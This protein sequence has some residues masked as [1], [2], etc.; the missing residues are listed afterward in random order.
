MRGLSGKYGSK[1]VN[2][3]IWEE[4]SATT[5]Q[6]LAEFEHLHLVDFDFEGCAKPCR[7][8]LLLRSVLW[9]SVYLNLKMRSKL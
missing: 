5:C 2:I 7:I 9:L 4:K 1:I 3:C 6:M 8:H